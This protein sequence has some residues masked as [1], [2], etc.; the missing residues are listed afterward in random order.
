MVLRSTSVPHNVSSPELFCG[1][2]AAHDPLSI[3][4]AFMNRLKGIFPYPCWEKAIL[5][6]LMLEMLL[7][8]KLVPRKIV[9]ML[10][11][12]LLELLL[13]F[14]EQLSALGPVI[15]LL[16]NFQSLEDHLQGLII[17]LLFLPLQGVA[18]SLW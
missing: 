15:L 11:Q 4:H 3:L 14:F 18:C 7:Q 6:Y 10:A 17:C 8:G 16:K 2:N 5:T 13:S 9:F 12:K 1:R